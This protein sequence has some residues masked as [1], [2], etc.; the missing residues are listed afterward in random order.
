MLLIDVFGFKAQYAVAFLL[1]ISFMV[2][3]IVRHARSKKYRY[4]NLVPG[5][6][7]FGN[8]FQMP[9]T[10]QGPFLEQLAKKYGEMSVALI[11]FLCTTHRPFFADPLALIIA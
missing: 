3:A 2:R 6:P 1:V 8:S 5:L 10:G 9:S 4:P 7:I 11:P